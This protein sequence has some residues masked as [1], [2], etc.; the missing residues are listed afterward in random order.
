M[1]NIIHKGRRPFLNIPSDFLNF[2][3]KQS[4]DDTWRGHLK[5]KVSDE[6]IYIPYDQTNKTKSI[7]NFFFLKEAKMGHDL[8]G[9]AGQPGQQR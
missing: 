6:Y 3:D 5:K 9:A 7:W 2:Q 4:H 1:I 8:I